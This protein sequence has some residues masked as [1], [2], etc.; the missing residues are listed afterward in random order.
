MKKQTPSE[1]A[2]QTKTKRIKENLTSQLKS[3]D[4]VSKVVNLSEAWAFP[5]EKQIKKGQITGGRL[6]EERGE[7]LIIGYG[8]D[9]MWKGFNLA[10][11]VVEDAYK[12]IKDDLINKMNK[13]KYF[14]KVSAGVVTVYKRKRTNK[15]GRI[16]L[17]FQELTGVKVEEI[18]LKQLKK[19]D[20][21][22]F[23]HVQ[24]L[25]EESLKA[26]EVNQVKKQEEEAKEISEIEVV[27][28][29]QEVEKAPEVA[30]VKTAQKETK[31][32]KKAKIIKKRQDYLKTLEG[33]EVVEISEMLTELASGHAIEL[34]KTIDVQASGLLSNVWKA[35]GG[36]YGEAVLA[37]SQLLEGKTFTHN[38]RAFKIVI[39]KGKKIK[40]NAI[41]KAMQLHFTEVE[42]I[43]NIKP[44]TSEATATAKDVTSSNSEKTKV[45]HLTEKT[46]NAGKTARKNVKQMKEGYK[47]AGR[48]TGTEPER[49][50]NYKKGLKEWKGVGVRNGKG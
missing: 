39:T 4:G 24:A 25:A 42:H 26:F 36:D 49:Y 30:P 18:T 27:Q 34:G 43:Q 41:G 13:N 9:V 47:Y 3:F 2:K 45:V 6:I 1:K 16:V 11:N 32:D 14:V 31:A 7:F 38:G 22:A 10:G 44:L 33:V 20:E 40:W 19:E 50:D 35:T 37:F 5:T 29:I 23:N 15:A 48:L 17:N 46:K 28:E 8:F 12:I 21:A